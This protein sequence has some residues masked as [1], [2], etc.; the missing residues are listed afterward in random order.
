MLDI[1]LDNCI[2][3]DFA[4]NRHEEFKDVLAR[5]KISTRKRFRVIFTETNGYE[6]LKGLNDDPAVLAVV[7]EKL[8]HIADVIYD[9]RMKQLGDVVREHVDA[10]ISG[11]SPPDICDT[12]GEWNELVSGLRDVSANPAKLL[13]NSKFTQGFREKK[14]R[15]REFYEVLQDLRKLP[16]LKEMSKGDIS[17]LKE[18][19]EAQRAR[20]SRQ[21]LAEFFLRGSYR[22]EGKPI[23]KTILLNDRF[24]DV[25]T[26]RCIIDLSFSF[27]YFN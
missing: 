16:A 22:K 11:Q 17:D 24:E 12:R 23:P 13:K 27:L 18:Y 1:I 15:D 6:A 2:Y 20:G 10:H 7:G 21:K 8:R 19:R 3:S 5:E 26:L 4:E 14:E 9:L 25:V